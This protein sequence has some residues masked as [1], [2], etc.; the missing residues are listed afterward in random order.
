MIK[1]EEKY[2]DMNINNIEAAEIMWKKIDEVVDWC[3]WCEKEVLELKAK[4]A[5][6]EGN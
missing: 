1:L 3:N 6:L 4:I 2:R 5:K